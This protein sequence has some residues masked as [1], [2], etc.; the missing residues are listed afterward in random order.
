MA[1]FSSCEGCPVN[2]KQTPQGVPFTLRTIYIQ[3]GQIRMAD[4]FDPTIPGQNLRGQFRTEGGQITCREFTPEN[5]E[6]NTV[7]SCAFVTHFEFR[8]ILATGANPGSQKVALE[9]AEEATFVADISADI[10]ADYMIGAPE[11]PSSDELQKWGSGNVL[12]HAWPYWREYCHASMSRMNLPVMLMPLL[13]INPPKQEK[14]D[15]ADA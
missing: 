3:K 11:I 10:V 13:Q 4:S 14:T 15:T 7:R 12:I 1:R 9:T 6:G 2:Q 8:Y 5:G